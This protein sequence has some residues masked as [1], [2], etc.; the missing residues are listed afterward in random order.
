MANKSVVSRRTSKRKPKASP[1]RIVNDEQPASYEIPSPGGP[2]THVKRLAFLA[3]YEQ[4]GSVKR[5][6]KLSGT[7]HVSVFKAV[8]LDP[9]FARAYRLAAEVNVDIVEDKLLAYAMNEERGNFGAA[10]A[11]LNGRRPATWR[12]NSRLEV[13]GSVSMM[14]SEVLR[15]AYDRLADGAGEA[16]H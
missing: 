15:T 2:F 12:Q 7:S 9:E 8:R 6:A 5:A 16:K 4:G 10:C 1:G 3:A 13:S 14:T 11:I